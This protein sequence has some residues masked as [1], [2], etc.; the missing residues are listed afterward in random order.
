MVSSCL[1]STG[2][3]VLGLFMLLASGLSPPLVVDDV[4]LDA[5]KDVADSLSGCCSDTSCLVFAFGI[6]GWHDSSVG[7][8]AP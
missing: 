4:G 3:F 7:I 1:A 5:V 6:L 8:W 2:L